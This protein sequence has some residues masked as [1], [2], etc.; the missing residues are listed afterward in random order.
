MVIKRSRMYVTHRLM[1]KHAC[2]KHGKIMKVGDR[3]RSQVKKHIHLTLRSKVN[4]ISG[5]CM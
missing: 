4:V 5:S 1:V 3:T 2:A